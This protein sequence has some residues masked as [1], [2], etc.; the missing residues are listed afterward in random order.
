MDS[1]ANWNFSTTGSG[2]DRNPGDGIS[3]A[4]WNFSTTGSGTD[5]NPGDGNWSGPAWSTG[6]FPLQ[7]VVLIGTQVMGSAWPTGTF[8]LQVVVLIGTQVMG[9]GQDQPGQL[10]LFHYR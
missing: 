7:V 4:N 1:L 6:T 9:T 5:R 8:P 3:L 10:K 2:T